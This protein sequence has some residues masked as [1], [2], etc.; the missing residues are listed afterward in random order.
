MSF[1]EFPNEFPRLETDRLVLRKLVNTDSKAVFKNYSDEE[2]SK[3]FMDKPFSELEQAIQL[4]DAFNKEFDQEKAIT[5]AIALKETNACI[6]TCSYMIESKSTVEIG[7]DLDKEY[8][9]KG[10][11][12]EA[13]NSII[14]HGFEYLGIEKIIADTMSTNMRSI[15]LLKGL[16]FQLID[17]RDNY[18]FFSLKK[19][20]THPSTI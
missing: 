13:L 5:W 19:V 3:N 17:V 6:G 9:G 16:G 1:L 18:H 20:Q 4:I 12:T 2:I 14:G 7:Y 10:L 11:M 8:W 15:N